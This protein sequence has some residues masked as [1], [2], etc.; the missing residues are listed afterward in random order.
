MCALSLICN[1]DNLSGVMELR[2]LTVFVAVAEEGS[3]TRAAERLHV[4]QSAVSASVRGLERELGASL[5]DRTTHHVALSD[6]GIALL[7]EARATLAAAAAAR[8]AVDQVRGGLR[9]TVTLGVMQALAMRAMSVPRLVATF[10]ER[11]PQVEVRIR[12]GGGS[13]DMAELIRE[14]RVDLGILALPERRAAGLALTL[15][16]SEP[17]FLVCPPG[18]RLARRADVELSMLA[19]ETFADAPAGWGTRMAVDRSFA[20]AGV[21]RTITY[22]VNDASAVIEFVEQGLAIALM[23]RF[24]AFSDHDLVFVPVRHHTPV[25][26]TSIAVSSERRLTA[27]TRALLEQAQQAA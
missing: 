24:A 22:E 3:F 8:E 1:S 27:A 21:R 20:A 9:G 10:R 16:S 2:H 23:P 18:H 7:P 26:E 25:F 12:H 5:F 13:A 14:G 6:A 19:D 17:I 15:L 4:V 11:H